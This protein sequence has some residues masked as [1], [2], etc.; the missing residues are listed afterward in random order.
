MTGLLHIN[1]RST[2]MS[3]RLRKVFAAGLFTVLL[4]CAVQPADAAPLMINYQGRVEVA[5]APHNGTGYFKFA[6]VDD[7]ASPTTNIWTN[8]G[9]SPAAG[10]QPVNPV[11]LSV[12]QGLFSLKL[13]DTDMTNMTALAASMFDGN[14]LY[15]RIWFSTD[16]FTFERLAPD[17]Q[18]VSVPYAF[19]SEQASDVTGSG[20]VSSSEIEDGTVSDADIS[21]SANIDVSKINTSSAS[22]LVSSITAGSGV[23]VSPASGVGDVTITATVDGQASDLV[24]TNCIESSD[25]TDGTVTTTDI[26][27]DPIEEGELDSEGK[28]ESQLT[29]VTDLFTDND[30]IDISSNTNL[31]ATAPITLSGDAV[32][33]NQNVGTDVTADLEEEGQINATGVTGDAA[34]D[35]VL[36]GSGVN[37]LAYKSLPDCSDS[38]GNHLNYDAASNAFSC[39]ASGAAESDPTLTDDG[40]VTFGAGSG[41]VTLSFDAD[42]GTDGTIAW[43]GA[44]DEWEI[45]NG[46]VGIGDTSP[47]SLFTVGAGDAFQINSSGSIAAATGMASTGTVDFSSATSLGIPAATAPALSAD[48]QIALETD[49]DAV[50][51]Q[52]GSGSAG[53]VPANTDVALPLVRQKDITLLEPDQIQVVS[54]AIPMFTVDSFN[55]PNGITITAIRLA[56]SSNS[57]LAVNVEEWVSPTDGAPVTIDNIATSSSTEITE[58][59]ISDASVAAGSYVMLD[60]DTTDI[61]WAKLTVWYYVND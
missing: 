3:N 50:N 45:A 10:A 30:T 55:Y 32:G 38:G 18:L 28:L 14:P 1:N 46:N 4:A 43:D 31:G 57:T 21:A 52:G 9:S 17:R 51:I 29:D 13:G 58:T 60:L 47:A 44:N 37:A 54:D 19:T 24:C 49:E 53:G 8:D 35:Q 42:G 16:G 23:T 2:A 56:T 59:T 6:L 33:I 5:G 36:L 61:N 12:N 15:L 34:D 7:P 48:G 20:V 27:F 41:S 26:A 40:A 11:S 22:N 25:I 39:G